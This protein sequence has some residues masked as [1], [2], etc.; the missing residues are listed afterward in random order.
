MRR[1]HVE[2]IVCGAMMAVACDGSPNRYGGFTGAP[3]ASLGIPSSGYGSSSG[4]KAPATA[5][6]GGAPDA[7]QPSACGK[8]L[9]D[10]VCCSEPSSIDYGQCYSPKCTGCCQSGRD[11]GSCTDGASCGSNESCCKKAGSL[12]YGQCFPSS[13]SGC[14]QGG[15]TVVDGGGDAGVC[16]VC[17]AGMVCC[18][19]AGALLFGKCYPPSCT[20]CCL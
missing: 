1:P 17:T 3:D 12:E 13:C 15:P 14:C 11:A 7:G 4:S 20:D 16:G 8:C 10:N 9:S 6:G 19:K 5:D 18:G 2:L